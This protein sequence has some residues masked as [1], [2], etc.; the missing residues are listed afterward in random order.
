MW[1]LTAFAEKTVRIEPALQ[2]TQN[3][4]YVLIT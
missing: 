3:R 2:V 1:L 4:L